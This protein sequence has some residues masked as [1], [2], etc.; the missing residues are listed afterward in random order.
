MA[1]RKLIVPKPNQA[2]ESF[3]CQALSAPSGLRQRQD[4]ALLIL[5]ATAPTK[6]DSTWNQAESY[7]I[8]PLMYWWNTISTEPNLGL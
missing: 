1:H 6:V 5:K 2:E 8:T 4:A 3:I 7:G